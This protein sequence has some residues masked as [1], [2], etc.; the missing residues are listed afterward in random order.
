MYIHVC[1]SVCI[2]GYVHRGVLYMAWNL[3]WQ[4]EW[5]LTNIILPLSITAHSNRS[6]FRLLYI[7]IACNE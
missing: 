4:F 6:Y 2:R 3:I 1:N 5:I 7:C